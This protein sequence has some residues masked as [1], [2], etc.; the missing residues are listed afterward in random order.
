MRGEAE[1]AK[2]RFG[3]FF[4]YCQGLYIIIISV[5]ARKH[6]FTGREASGKYV[7]CRCWREKYIWINVKMCFEICLSKHLAESIMF[8]LI[9]NIYYSQNWKLRYRNLQYAYVRKILCKWHKIYLL[10][11]TNYE[12]KYFLKYLLK[13]LTINYSNSPISWTF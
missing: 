7:L 10:T 9:Y 8:V 13:W 5:S 3:S 1:D 2:L 12:H 11:L 6:V 4:F